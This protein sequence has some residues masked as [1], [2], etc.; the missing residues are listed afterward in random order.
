MRAIARAARLLREAIHDI[1]TD[2]SARAAI[3]EMRD[4]DYKQWRQMEWIGFYF[5]FLCERIF[6][7]LMDIPGMTYGRTQFDGFDPISWDFKAHSNRTSASKTSNVVI[8]NDKEA[9]DAAIDDYG[10]Y[11]LVLATGEATYN[12]DDRTFQRWHDDLKGGPSAYQKRRR[13]EGAVSRRRKVHF[14]LSDISFIALNSSTLAECGAI[15]QQGRNS[16]NKPRPPK[17][18]VN[19]KKVPQAALLAIAS[20]D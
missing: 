17:Y 19:T 3:L 1:P 16:N 6:D 12:D 14:A 9:I 15:H 20:F 8:T 11:G 5:Q 2:W 13:E 18:S 10:W 4:A 7:E